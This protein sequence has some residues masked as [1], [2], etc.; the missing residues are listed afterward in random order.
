[1]FF[2]AIGKTGL[3]LVLQ[4]HLRPA[5]AKPQQR[6]QES[7]DGGCSGQGDMQ[8]PHCGLLASFHP[9]IFFPPK[10]GSAVISN[11]LNWFEGTDGLL[12]VSSPLIRAHVLNPASR[13]SDKPG[14]CDCSSWCPSR[15]LNLARDGE[16]F[17]SH[18]LV[19]VGRSGNLLGESLTPAG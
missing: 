5:G 10:I 4:G 18:Q 17:L 19:A 3:H 8:L 2:I 13:G 11:Y 14:R 12:G 6:I 9:C 16:C 15:A 7:L 1:M